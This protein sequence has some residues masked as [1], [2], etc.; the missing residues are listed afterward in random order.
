LPQ[1]K[2]PFPGGVWVLGPFKNNPAQPNIFFFVS[3]NPY[4]SKARGSSPTPFTSVHNVRVIWPPPPP[5]C[6]V[7]GVAKT[8]FP[9]KGYFWPHTPETGIFFFGP[10]FLRFPPPWAPKSLLLQ[11]SFLWGTPF[12]L[13]GLVPFQGISLRENHFPPNL[14]G[15]WDSPPRGKNKNPFFA[16]C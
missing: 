9:G 15:A 16:P 14:A 4:C 1:T 13:V 6:R 12:S 10:F 2:K 11:K 8:T 3:Q 7:G 5:P